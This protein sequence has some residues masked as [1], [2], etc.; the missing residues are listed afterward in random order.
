MR[1]VLLTSWL[2]A[3]GLN[4]KSKAYI[5]GIATQQVGIHG[6]KYLD[7]VGVFGAGEAGSWER[8]ILHLHCCRP[9]FSLQANQHS[10]AQTPA[11]GLDQ[12]SGGSLNERPGTEAVR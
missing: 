9:Q 3:C 1:S 10:R 8:Y 4:N 2:I 6:T 11:A 7:S 5:K 12:T